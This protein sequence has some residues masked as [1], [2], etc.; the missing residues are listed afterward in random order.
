MISEIRGA[1]I[2]DLA[3]RQLYAATYR[4]FRRRRS[5]LLLNLEK[6]IQIEELPW[7]AAVDRFRSE[8]LSSREL[9]KQTL[10]E[11]TLLAITSFPF[12]ILP[13]KLLQELRALAKGADLTIPLVDE[14]AADIFMG[15]FSQKFPESAKRA[16][17]LLDRSLYATYFGID[18]NEVRSIPE[19][20]ETKQRFRWETTRTAP[21]QDGHPVDENLWLASQPIIE[22]TEENWPAYSFAEAFHF[23]APGRRPDLASGETR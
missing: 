21:N 10:H 8:N 20:E 12:A 6:Q 15:E 13:N 7:V 16:A 17:D 11:V 14:V 18:Y 23:R 3:L 9:A 5:L 2:A 19:A 1:G 4:A 22:F